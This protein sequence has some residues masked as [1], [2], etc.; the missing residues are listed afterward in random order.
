MFENSLYN[1]II[2]NSSPTKHNKACGRFCSSIV[3]SMGLLVGVLAVDVV[4]LDVLDDVGIS[5][6]NFSIA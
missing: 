5:Y 1:T 6:I 3:V 2:I 4:M